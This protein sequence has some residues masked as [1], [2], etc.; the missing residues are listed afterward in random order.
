MEDSAV[1]C[2]DNIWYCCIAM[3]CLSMCPDLHRYIFQNGP[4]VEFDAKILFYQLFDAVEAIGAKK[5]VHR[6]LSPSNI[7]YDIEYK[8]P[9][10]IDFGGSVNASPKDRIML[11]PSP[12]NLTMPEI[13]G[14]NFVAT[15]YGNVL[16]TYQLGVIMYFVLN[17]WF[18]EEKTKVADYPLETSFQTREFVEKCIHRDPR[19]RQK[20]PLIKKTSF[21]TECNK[22]FFDYL[23]RTLPEMEFQRSQQK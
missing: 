16:N 17:G 3:P 14:K 22:I 10:I 8:Y 5:I 7:L 12:L 4:M 9:F 11:G 13:R 20:F 18:P 15:C 1:L 19:I 21:Y 6:D 2:K 23:D